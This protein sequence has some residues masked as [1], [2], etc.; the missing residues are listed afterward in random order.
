[1]LIRNTMYKLRDFIEENKH[2]L[3]NGYLCNNKSLG[4]IKFLDNNKNF[5]N[6]SNLASNENAIYFKYFRDQISGETF[7][8]NPILE[9]ESFGYLIEKYFELLKS[10]NISWYY[11]NVGYCYY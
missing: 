6:Y 2:K 3:H 5:I 11:Y 10:Q 8:D 9:N 1:M 7:K 4:L